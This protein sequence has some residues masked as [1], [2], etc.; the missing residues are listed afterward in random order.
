VQHSQI[1]EGLGSRI[2]HKNELT[3]EEC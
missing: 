3:L 2:N 1:G